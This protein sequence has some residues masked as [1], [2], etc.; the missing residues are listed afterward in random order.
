MSGLGAAIGEIGLACEAA[1]ARIDAGMFGYCD[2]RQ[3]WMCENCYERYVAR[4]D[5]A[6]VDEL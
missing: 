4:R 2:A 1:N 6:F 5:L 3:Q